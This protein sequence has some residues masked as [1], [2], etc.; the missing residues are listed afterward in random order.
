M[1]L[2]VYVTGGWPWAVLEA[3]S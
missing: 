3:W 2:A 1:E